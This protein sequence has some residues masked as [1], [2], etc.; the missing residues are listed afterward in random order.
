M[1]T[2][3]VGTKLVALCRE[4]KFDEAMNSLYADDCVQR[5]A[6]AMPG[7]P[8]E[9][10]GLPAIQKMSE[11]WSRNTKVFGFTCSDPQIHDDRFAVWME[12]DMEMTGMPRMKVHEIGLYTV[13][14]GKVS[15]I[16][17][18]SEPRG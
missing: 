4:G 10:V 18:F 14:N 8:R 5:E 6:D 7:Q 16:E 11:E 9:W 12:I 2:N 1:T 3:E 17:F 13:K 15:R